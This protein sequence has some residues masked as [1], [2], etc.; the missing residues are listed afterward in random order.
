MTRVATADIV[1]MAASAIETARL[2]LLSGFPDHSGKPGNL[3][4]LAGS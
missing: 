1:V 2:A 4:H 3:R